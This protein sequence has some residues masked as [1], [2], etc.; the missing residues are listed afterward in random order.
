MGKN[1]LPVWKRRKQRIIYNQ[2]FK[3][4]GL[5]FTYQLVLGFYFPVRLLHNFQE[6]GLDAK[7]GRKQNMNSV[8]ELEKKTSKCG[9]VGIGFRCLWF[10]L[11][12][13]LERIN[14]NWPIRM[15]F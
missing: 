14:F 8:P 11:G 15:S 12:L 9:G 10:G 7:E 4:K 3:N 5:I 13:F 2:Q 6:G 1:G